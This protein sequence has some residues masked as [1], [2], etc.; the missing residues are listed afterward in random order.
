M[1][2]AGILLSVLILIFILP[3]ISSLNQTS[4]AD[5]IACIKDKV[6]EK[7]CSAFGLESKIFALLSTGQCEADVLSVDSNDECFVPVNGNSCELK[8]TSQA[9]LA[10]DEGGSAD[11]KKYSDW[12][13]AQN[14]TA[15]GIDWLL[16]IETSEP[17]LCNLEDLNAD[18]Y[19]VSINQEKKLSLS[20]GNCLSLDSSGYWLKIDSQCQKQE[21]TVSCDKA[22]QVNLLFK[23]QLSSTIYVFDESAKSET[24]GGTDFIKAKESL[25]FKKGNSCDYEGSLWAA[26]VLKKLGKDISSYLP[27]LIVFEED[28]EKFLPESFL[29]FLTAEQDFKTEL[30]AKQIGDRYWDEAYDRYYDTALALMGVSSEQTDAKDNAINWLA[31]VQ[32]ADGCWD[33]GNVA[34]TGFLL[35]S[36]WPSSFSG[37]DDGELPDNCEDSG[38]FCIS[39]IECSEAGGD[40]LSGY[41]CPGLSVCCTNDKPSQ[42]CSELGG[43]VCDSS[44]DCD[45]FSEYGASDLL[46]NEQCCVGTCEAPTITTQ[47]ECEQNF[48]NCR[49]TACGS[50]EKE[51][52]SYL[53]NDVSQYCCMQKTEGKSFWWLWV[54]GIL[55]ILTALAIRFKDKLKDFYDK[56]TTKKSAPRPGMPPRMHEVP[57]R[58]ILPQQH[59]QQYPTRRPI[60]QKSELDDV[61]KKLKEM[62]K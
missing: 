11:T 8:T 18:T 39:D 15:T 61:L 13:L 5:A 27:Y 62:G 52:L 48:G 29:Y 19:Q 3:F 56:F 53:C 9:V 12:I 54:L 6:Q 14:K 37:T 24:A 16:Q 17:A 20:G 21:F 25:C 1:K 26:L 44:E 31:G 28:N 35:Y 4:N 33:S 60:P 45:G 10:L 41:N 58:R 2:K 59:H 30:L 22:F 32:G 57:Q 55:I 46:S 50:G 40:S 49:D 23:K 7:G 34:K 36:L 51:E 43:E 38:N 42:T 47:S